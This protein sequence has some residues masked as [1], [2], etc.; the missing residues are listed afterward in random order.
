[1]VPLQVATVSET[2]DFLKTWIAYVGPLAGT[3]LGYIF[4]DSVTR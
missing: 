2:F 4:K 3:I 1:M